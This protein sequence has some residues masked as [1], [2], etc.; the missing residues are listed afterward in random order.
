MDFLMRLLKNMRPLASDIWLSKEQK[1]VLILAKGSRE[2]A[3]IRKAVSRLKL[4]H[5]VRTVALDKAISD[6]ALLS[7]ALSATSL[8]SSSS[9]LQGLGGMA[10]AIVTYDIT[11]LDHVKKTLFGYALRGRSSRKGVLHGLG[12]YTLGRN[13]VVIPAEKMPELE[14]FL[15]FWKATYS[16][17]IMIDVREDRGSKDREGREGR[18]NREDWE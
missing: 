8:K 10:V 6:N 7:F 14:E 16:K 5:T 12:G 3:V 9:V 15:R 4:S 17:R 2:E 13:N 1:R 11:S 18:G